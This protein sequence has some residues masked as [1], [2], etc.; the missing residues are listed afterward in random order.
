MASYA[1]EVAPQGLP[2]IRS[3]RAVLTIALL[4]LASCAS[5][6]FDRAPMTCESEF[7]TVRG[8]AAEDVEEVAS[9]VR[10]LSPRVQEILR[11]EHAEPVR[12]VVLDTPTDPSAKAYTHEFVRDGRIVDRFIVVGS[13]VR[14]L[15]AFLVAHE[16]VHWF[17]DGPWDRLPLALEEGLADLIASQLDP[18]GR[19]AKLY[20]LAHVPPA[21]SFEEIEAALRVTRETW[22][23]LTAAEHERAYWVGYVVAS[24]IGVGG[25]REL[26][27]QSEVDGLRLVSPDRVVDRMKLGEDV[28]AWTR[29]LADHRPPIP[30][31]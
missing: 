15:R 1:R 16:C 4:A 7:G 9:L 24:R 14:H 10:D 31:R 20:D 5:T 28:Q 6:D 29:E 30:F 2:R 22:A 12:V 3:M 8:F 11:P 26:A 13:E 19:E 18:I 17:A 23:G 27:E 25:L 21:A